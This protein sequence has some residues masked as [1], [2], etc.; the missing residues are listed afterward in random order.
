[1]LA[2]PLREA[3]PT[4]QKPGKQGVGHASLLAKGV[5]SPRHR[6]LN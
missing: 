1:M 3:R 5:F 2:R 6:S 4:T